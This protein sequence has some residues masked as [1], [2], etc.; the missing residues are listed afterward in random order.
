[1]LWIYVKLFLPLDT[2]WDDDDDDDD[3]DD[4]DDDDAN[5]GDEEGKRMRTRTYDDWFVCYY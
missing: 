3:D 2:H 5:G 1:M 4:I